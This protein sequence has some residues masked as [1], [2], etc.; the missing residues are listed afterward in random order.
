MRLALMER[1][2]TQTG[3]WISITPPDNPKDAETKTEHTLSRIRVSVSQRAT[4]DSGTGERKITASATL[5]FKAGYSAVD[6]AMTV[7]SF[8]P[9]DI[10]ISP[11]EEEWTVRGTVRCAAPDGSLHHLE[12][13]LA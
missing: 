3:R 11:M 5:F 4:T 13:Q 1:L 6:G 7:P 10:L 12:V 9:G 2:F 8:L